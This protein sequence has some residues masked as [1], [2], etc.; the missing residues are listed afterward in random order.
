MPTKAK[1][2]AFFAKYSR[3]PSSPPTTPVES[4][5]V[6]QCRCALAVVHECRRSHLT[7]ADVYSSSC[8]PLSKCT[9]RHVRLSVIRDHSVNVHSS[10]VPCLL[11]SLSCQVLGTPDTAMDTPPPVFTGAP[12]VPC[13]DH[14]PPSKHRR[15]AESTLV[16]KFTSPSD[17]PVAASCATTI[18]VDR[19]IEGLGVCYW[20]CAVS[21]RCGSATPIHHL[22]DGA[23]MI[24]RGGPSHSPA[25]SIFQ[26]APEGY[27]RGS[28]LG[29]VLVPP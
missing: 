3:G 4:P 28:P 25:V 18:S 17:V 9:C 21:G 5:T 16:P 11:V 26:S 8:V 24:S 1:L 19:K 23:G 14:T 7:S 22:A 12:S 13:E 29:T 15:L 2:E 6:P 10:S 20:V 27:L